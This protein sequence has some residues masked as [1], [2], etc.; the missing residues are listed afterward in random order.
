VTIRQAR[1]W[2]AIQISPAKW[3]QIRWRDKSGGFWVVAILDSTVVWYNDIED[4]F[5]SS[6]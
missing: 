3:A 6:R 2:A 1:L 4:G 5:N